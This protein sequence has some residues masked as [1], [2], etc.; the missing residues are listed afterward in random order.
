MTEFGIPGAA[1]INATWYLVEGKI[2]TAF[3]ILFINPLDF[4]PGAGV[5]KTI[6]KGPKLLKLT[7]NVADGVKDASRLTAGAGNNLFKTQ[8]LFD[9]HYAKH[10]DEFGNITKD[11]YLKRAQN[12]VNSNPG[13]NILTKTRANGDI[14]YYNMATNEFAIKASDGTIRTYFKPVEGIEYFNR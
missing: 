1:P 13:D 8:E 9:A 3:M 5:G 10:A 4:V 7:D 6:T 14:L 12:L 2:G 11:Q